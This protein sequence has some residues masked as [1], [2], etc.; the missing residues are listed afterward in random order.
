M[1]HA[2]Q[3]PPPGLVA[4]TASAQFNSYLG[5]SFLANFVDATAAP[6]VI[7]RSC[8]QDQNLDSYIGHF[9]SGRRHPS[10]RRYRS[11]RR[12][13]HHPIR[14]RSR[15][16][17]AGAGSQRVG[18]T[19]YLRPKDGHQMRGIR[20]PISLAIFEASQHVPAA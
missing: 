19:R 9:E 17:E 10:V 13:G 20:E 1:S 4:R 8:P 14:K 16:F 6:A 2:L 15:D 5:S 12:S 11:A 3:N 7:S 18:L